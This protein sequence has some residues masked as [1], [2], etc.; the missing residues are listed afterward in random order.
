MNTEL[1]ND[2]LELIREWFRFNS[3]IT[4]FQNKFCMTM[5]KEWFGDE[6][7]ERL[8][9]NFCTR[10]DRKFESFTTYLLPEQYNLLMTNILRYPRFG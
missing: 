1:T 7:G 9:I 8:F 2:E 4:E 3:R 6:E 10:C 5:A